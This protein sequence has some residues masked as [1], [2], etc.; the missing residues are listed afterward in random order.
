MG[1]T[2]DKFLGAILSDFANDSLRLV[3]ADWLEEHGDQRRADYLR[4]AVELRQL[5]QGSEGRA[6]LCEGS[7]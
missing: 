5:P 3:Y 4:K 2:D 1:D 6:R 7:R